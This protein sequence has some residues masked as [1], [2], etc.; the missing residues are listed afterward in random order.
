MDTPTTGLAIE[1]FKNKMLSLLNYKG[2]LKDLKAKD[3]IKLAFFAV[4]VWIIA[5]GIGII[6]GFFTSLL[7][8]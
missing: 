8:L 5:F 2:K 6:I 4:L 3:K 1:N 7:L